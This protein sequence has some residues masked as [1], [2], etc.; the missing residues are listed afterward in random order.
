MWENVSIL[1]SILWLLAIESYDFMHMGKVKECWKT[2]FNVSQ[3]DMVLF[4][5]Y[6]YMNNTKIKS[7]YYHKIYH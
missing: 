5:L 7:Y 2:S 1:G 3:R 4:L 6:I